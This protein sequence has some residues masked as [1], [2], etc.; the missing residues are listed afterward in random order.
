[1]ENEGA[2]KETF[3]EK[4]NRWK[5]Q[6]WHKFLHDIEWR[7]KTLL[8]KIK[9]VLIDWLLLLIRNLT[10]PR[11]NP[12]E[13]NKLFAMLTPVCGI[14]F[15][16]FSFVSSADFV[17]FFTPG[18]GIF[19][20]IEMFGVSIPIFPIVFAI[21]CVLGLLILF[22]SRMG[23]APFYFPVFVFVCFFM[24]IVWI[25]AIANN[26]LSVLSAAGVSIGL[27]EVLLATTVL[28]WGN[29][30]GDIVADVI[31][32]RQGF[33]EM[34]VGAIYAGPMSNLLLGLGSSVVITSLKSGVFCYSFGRNN[35]V[36][37]ITI[38]FLI[39]TLLMSVV[40]VPVFRFKFS[41][42]YGV[43]LFITY[44]GYVV[45]VVV[46]IFFL[47]KIDSVRLFLEWPARCCPGT[48]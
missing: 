40:V 3:G 5:K 19:W 7:H 9:F 42:I 41:K 32:A 30:I 35:P 17:S 46:Y 10:I 12:R 44:G 22:T 11:A 21:G 31:I 23:H 16:Y 2:Y 25:Y 20:V 36:V 29:A 27:P 6:M 13:W 18:T 34:A 38:A 14:P 15:A 37:L 4:L 1:M 43:F 26:L 28:C 24:S 47:R 33:S 8:G 48:C 39:V 45:V